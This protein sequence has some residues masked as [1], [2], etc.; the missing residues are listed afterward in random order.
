LFIIARDKILEVKQPIPALAYGK[1]MRL[2]AVIRLI[3]YER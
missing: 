3:S 1:Q 2:S